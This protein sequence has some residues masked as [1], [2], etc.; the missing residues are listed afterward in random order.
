MKC[1]FGA[2]ELEFLWHYVLKNGIKMDPKKIEAIV[3]WPSP[4]NIA[5][6]QA[7]LGLANYYRC[8][9][10]HYAEIQ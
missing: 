5:K 8:F 4:K 9:V 2:F 1:I 3:A 6:V 7:F 10:Q